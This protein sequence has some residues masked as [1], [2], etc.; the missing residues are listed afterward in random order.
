[1][2]SDS[3]TTATAG[4]ANEVPYTRNVAVVADD[5]SVVPSS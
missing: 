1:M 4:G 3:G 5:V 2:T